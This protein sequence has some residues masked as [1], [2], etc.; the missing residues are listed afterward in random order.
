MSTEVGRIDLGLDVNKKMFNKQLSGIAG[1]AEKQVKSAFGG[2]GSKIGKT[3]GLALG[4]AMLVSF[5]KSSLKLGS[6]LSEVQNVVDVTFKQMSDSVNLFASTAIETFG[7]SETLAKKYMGV[8]GAMSKSM[9]MTE[10][11]AFSM[12]KSITGL[13]GDVASFYNLSADEAYTKLKSI[14]TGETETLKELGIIMTQ[15][16]LDNYALNN[17]LGKTTKTMTE[18][19]KLMLRY[20]YV[21]SRLSDA[22]GDFARTSD[23]WANQTRVLSLRFD[24]LKATLGQGLINL[25][26]P[27]VKMINTVLAKLQAL[28]EAFKRF[29]EMLTGRKSESSGLGSAASDITDATAGL[30]GEVDGLGSEATK[31]A[32]KIQKSLAGFD[33]LNV[34]TANGDVESGIGGAS[35]SGAGLNADIAAGTEQAAN[36]MAAALDKVRVKLSELSGLFKDGFTVGFGESDIDQIT[37]SALRIKDSLKGIFTSPEVAGAV[38]GWVS[39]VTSSVGKV[40]GSFASVGN[41]AADLLIGSVDRYLSQNSGFLKNKFVS[42]LDI[43]SRATEIY[44]DFTTAMADV[45]T[46]FRSDPAKQ[47]GSDLIAIFANSFLSLTELG[48]QFGTDLLNMITQPIIN[49][50]DAIKLAL[51]NTLNPVRTLTSGI[52]AFLDKAF[53]SIKK[54]YDI[55]ISPALKN[56]GDGFSTVYKGILDGYNQ[57]LAPTIDRISGK[58]TELVNTYLSPLI[59]KITTFI[60]TLIYEVSR[61]WDFLS[62][63]VSWIVK[64]FI[65]RISAKLEMIWVAFEF[66]FK[67]IANLVETFIGVAQGL[68]DFIVGVFTGDWERAWGGIEQIFTSIVGGLENSVTNFVDFIGKAFEGIGATIKNTFKGAINGVISLFNKFIGW[69]NS[70]L[71]FS[72]DGLKIA[73]KTIFDGGSVQLAKIPSIPALAKGGIVDTPTLAMIGEKGKEAVVPLED[74]SFVSTLASAIAREIAKVIG[75]QKN[76][77]N[78]GG[79]VVLKVGEAEFARIAIKSIN[80]EQR[81]AGET[82]LIV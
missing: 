74:T 56:F 58:F 12:A 48:W 27:I 35:S 51:E 63:F 21:M 53:A 18:Q 62:P 77:S 9:G 50:K 67:Q 17:G 33:E 25:F 81:R 6:N 26:T 20:Q 3:L 37:A 11:Q 30:N 24:A 79:D 13:S 71:K 8:Y 68:L 44:S 45:Y 22:Q 19:E 39:K 57:Y 1:G 78:D 34:L 7:L 70:K 15:T 2:M 10:K 47:I 64:N 82:L 4:G 49:N 31:A 61:L 66:V 75:T 16:N 32:K 41:T 42:L 72:W 43:S 52:R 76:S 5:T 40:T 28:A 46:V 59:D 54:S 38:D 80:N 14:W 65:E 29:T 23:S 55:Y 36:K 69:V 73:G 60:G